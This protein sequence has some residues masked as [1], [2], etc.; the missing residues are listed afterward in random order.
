MVVAEVVVDTGVTRWKA[1]YVSDHSTVTGTV[2]RTN[3]EQR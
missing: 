1:G 2:N 3:E